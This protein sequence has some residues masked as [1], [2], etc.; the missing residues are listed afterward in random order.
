MNVVLKKTSQ[1]FTILKLFKNGFIQNLLVM[2]EAKMMT[3]LIANF[4]DFYFTIF[5]SIELFSVNVR[6]NN[7][8]F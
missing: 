6:M 5:Y 2:S 7:F 8:N 1:G 4:T 3:K